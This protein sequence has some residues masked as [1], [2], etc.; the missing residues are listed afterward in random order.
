M[1][2]IERGVSNLHSIA[3]DTVAK[4]EKKT[5]EEKKNR[6]QQKVAVLKCCAKSTNAI[7]FVHMICRCISSCLSSERIKDTFDSLKC[8]T[9]SSFEKLIRRQL[10]LMT[11]STC[12]RAPRSFSLPSFSLFLYLFL[13]FA[14]TKCISFGACTLNLF[15]VH[16][17]AAVLNPGAFRSNLE[18]LCLHL[19]LIWQSEHGNAI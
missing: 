11:S 3:I 2:L 8:I 15:D 18:F 19:T 16:T 5:W 1:L 9:H 13:R 4:K 12:V 17:N 10:N 14:F 6:E 7:H